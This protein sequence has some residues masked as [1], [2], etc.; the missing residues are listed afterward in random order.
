MITKYQLM[1]MIIQTQIG[2][3]VIGLPYAVHQKAGS[4]GWISV[5]IAGCVIQLLI[6]CYWLL[7][8]RY[9]GETIFTI[10][11]RMLGKF[12]GILVGISYTVFGVLIS[13]LV[14]VLYQDI[15]SLWVLPSTPRWVII[16]IM[17]G[18][19][20]YLAKENMK[21][22]ARFFMFVTA[23]IPILIILVLVSFPH[24]TEIRYLFPIGHNGMNNIISG[25]NS[26][27]FSIIGI[28][29]L[30]FL[31][32]YTEGSYRDI[33]KFSSLANL[34]TTIFYTFLVIACSIVFAPKEILII[35]QPVL[36]MLKSISFKLVE[37]IDLLF[38]S[39]WIVIVATS[40]I[41]YLLLASKGSAH[42]FSI[43]QH[44][45]P[46]YFI[47]FIVFV[48]ALIPETQFDIMKLNS[49]IGDISYFFIVG[50]PLFLLIVSFFKKE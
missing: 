34:F 32:M 19:C 42:L 38:F 31:S 11:E 13:T 24:H 4:D 22:I 47:A 9:P 28:E 50:L 6:L 26:V 15:I 7:L 33:L 40:L 17:I 30:F 12:A 39:V 25:A 27:I 29:M 43:K 36:Y 49:F 23:L 14:L 21:I 46:L 37:R 1:F 16:M 44:K 5:L 45:K 10:S 18:T 41:S 48:C 20:L 3:G 8:R 35:P 2:V